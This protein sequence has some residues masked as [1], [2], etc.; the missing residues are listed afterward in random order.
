MTRGS[1]APCS[2]PILTVT[3]AGRADGLKTWNTVPPFGTSVFWA[4]DHVVDDAV[5]PSTTEGPPLPAGPADSSSAATT[6]PDSA[7]T[8][9]ARA[10]LFCTWSPTFST[11]RVWAGTSI[12]W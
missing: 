1:A 6:A 2:N 3:R 12:P 8:A 7:T 10:G 9:V 5:A 11:T 4:K